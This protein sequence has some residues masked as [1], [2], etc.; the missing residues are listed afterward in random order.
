MQLFAMSTS[1]NYNGSARE[2]ATESISFRLEH[3]ALNELR[4]LASERKM[5]LNS[6]ISQILDNYLKVGLYDKTFGFFSINK[7]T[8]RLALSR[9]KED[10][11]LAIAQAGA[12][13]HRQVIMYLFGRINK[14]TVVNYLSIYGNRF[15]TFRHLKERG[16]R[17]IISFFHGINMQFSMLYYDIT[18]M[19]LALA[20]IKTVESERDVSEEGFTI[21]FNYEA[22]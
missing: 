9:V 16:G 12:K 21:V 2:K 4:T 3:D 7:E 10:E 19:I 22:S 14:E 1:S 6:L 13:I 17:N 8:L 5:S 15:D 20:D 18:R 11:L